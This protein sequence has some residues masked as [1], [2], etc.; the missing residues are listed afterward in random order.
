M[1]I[2]YWGS[3]KPKNRS[4]IN[5]S[6]RYDECQGCGPVIGNTDKVQKIHHE[7]ERRLTSYNLYGIFEVHLG[8]NH[9]QSGYPD[10]FQ[11][12]NIQRKQL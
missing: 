7:A 9:A 6:A 3:F 8:G 5:I 4:T 10:V 11:L 1:T 12:H 2:T